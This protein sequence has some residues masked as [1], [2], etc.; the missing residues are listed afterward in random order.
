MILFSTLRLNNMNDLLLVSCPPICLSHVIRVTKNSIAACRLRV[1]SRSVCDG[2]C[3]SVLWVAVF[4]R[5]A[6]TGTSFYELLGNRLVMFIATITG[7]AGSCATHLSATSSTLDRC[8]DMSSCSAVLHEQLPF[9]PTPPALLPWTP[10]VWSIII[11]FFLTLASRRSSIWCYWRSWPTAWC[12]HLKGTYQETTKHNLPS[13][14]WVCL[15]P[16]MSHSSNWL[17]MVFSQTY[18]MFMYWLYW[19]AARI[20]T[21]S[22]NFTMYLFLALSL[23][24]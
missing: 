9:K 18:G 15:T 22:L 13:S 14:W 6:P 16:T 3:L 8:H 23:T 1:T 20:L 11:E 5:S 10:K 24:W 12:L 17:R 4:E 7:S 21:T 2:C 19:I